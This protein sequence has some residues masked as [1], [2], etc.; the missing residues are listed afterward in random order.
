MSTGRSK[1]VT[2]LVA[3]LLTLGLLLGS[4]AFALEKQVSIAVD[5]S[6]IETKV[7]F[8]STV[9][10]VLDQNN[11][12]L[13]DQDSVNPS[14]ETVITQEQQ[15]IVNRAFLVRVTADGTTKEIKTTPVSAAT[16]VAKA[17][18][19]VGERDIIK[20]S[21]QEFSHEIRPQPLIA[22]ALTANDESNSASAGILAGKTTN[23]GLAPVMGP[24]RS[25]MEL[26]SPGQEIEVIRVT[27]REFAV[28]E[29]TPYQVEKTID[30]NLEVGIS[31]TVQQGKN[32]LTR[33]VF[34]ITCHNGQ[35]I[36]RETIRNEVLAQP[37]NQV[38][39]V[40]NSYTVS[41]GGQRFDFRE[42]KT[43][44]ATAYTYT[45]NRTATG[46]YPA[47]GMVA[48]DPKVISLGTRMYIEGYGYATATDTGG[49]IK[50]N[51][52]DVFMETYSQ[53]MNW[54]RRT[55]KV[56]LLP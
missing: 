41:R 56:Y 55:V 36:S 30:A 21:N 53:C 39:A 19:L 40:G 43:M 31:K 3:S 15:I 37:Q 27:Q 6:V 48:V 44:V 28:D 8:S 7:L 5:G 32:G 45:G 16:A 52:I 9:G 2:L 24:A 10:V 20:V 4:M 22:S 33:H 23:L 38:I 17:G 1:R 50:G 51:R 29:P 26:I 13:A 35:E 46:V 42:A 25:H 14:R 12:V 49:A 47:T 18:F 34:L 54:G 11:I